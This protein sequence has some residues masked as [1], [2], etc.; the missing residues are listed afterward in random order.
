MRNIV[1]VCV[2]LAAFLV[3]GTASAGLVN[4]ASDFKDFVNSLQIKTGSFYNMHTNEWEQVV[5]GSLY[6]FEKNDI[7]IFSIEAA[8][9]RD[10]AILG[11]F[12]LNITGLEQFGW[13]LP[14]G[15]LKPK[16]AI[17]GGYD[18]DKRVKVYGM[19]LFGFS[20]GF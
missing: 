2:L 11:L 14:I 5:A 17:G 12:D 15:T 16:V 1:A 9:M 20:L 8:Y 4:K 13:A 6:D 3:V 10:K 7:P 19:A 18:F